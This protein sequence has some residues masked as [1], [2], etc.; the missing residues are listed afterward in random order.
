MPRAQRMT[1]F[2]RDVALVTVIPK[3]EC[4]AQEVNGTRTKMMMRSTRL[5]PSP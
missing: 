5:P 1:V 3:F 4:F 2:T